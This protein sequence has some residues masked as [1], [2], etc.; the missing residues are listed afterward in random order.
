MDSLQ[1]GEE[2]TVTVI[3]E[4][5]GTGSVSKLAAKLADIDGVVSVNAGD[6]NVLSE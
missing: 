4:I 6:V 1:S 2:R 3:L 5:Q